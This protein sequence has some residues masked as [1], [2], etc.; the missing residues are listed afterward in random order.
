MGE[1]D[2]AGQPQTHGNLGFICLIVAV[3]T[4]GGVLLVAAAVF[5]RALTAC[6]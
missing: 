5:K 3:A 4:I 1:D 6:V 2:M